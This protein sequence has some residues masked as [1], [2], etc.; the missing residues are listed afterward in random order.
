MRVL[1]FGKAARS[2]EE[3]IKLVVSFVEYQV[4]KDMFL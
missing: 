1:V 4:G 2:P 3:L